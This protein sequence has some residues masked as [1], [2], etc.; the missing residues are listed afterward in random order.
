MHTFMYRHK[1]VT[2]EYVHAACYDYRTTKTM[3]Y[4]SSY[5]YM[6]MIGKVW[7]CRSLFVFF[8]NFV[9]LY[10]YGFLRRG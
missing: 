3:L 9:C 4:F 5:P 2:S 1:V 8:C 10:G 6:L 7:I